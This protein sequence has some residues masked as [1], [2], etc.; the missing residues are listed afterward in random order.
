MLE[1]NESSVTRDMI[2]VHF[3]GDHTYAAVLDEPGVYAT[4][5]VA[6]ATQ[7]LSDERL[8]ALVNIYWRERRDRGDLAGLPFCGMEPEAL[9]LLQRYLDLSGDVQTVGWLA[10]R[11]M[12]PALAKEPGPQE[13]FTCYSALLDSWRMWIP[14]AEFD[15]AM[16]QACLYKAPPLQACQ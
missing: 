1:R 2:V 6:F 11:C 4:D 15:I 8:A 16:G 14:R 12:R 7:Y 10:A 3:Q 9:E 13:W 5:K